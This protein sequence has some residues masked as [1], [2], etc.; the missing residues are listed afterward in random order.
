[1]NATIDE[2]NRAA[3]ERRQGRST[4]ILGADVVS[5]SITW[6]NEL[7]KND[8]ISEIMI[9][10]LDHIFVEEAGVLK[11]LPFTIE[12]WEALDVLVNHIMKLCGI[13]KQ[14]SI[15]YYDGMLPDGS[16][17]AIVLPP[18][19]AD[20]ISIAVRKKCKNMMTFDVMVERGIMPQKVADFMKALAEVRVSVLI[21]GSTSSGKTTLLNALSAFI[22]KD[23]RV[24]T[25]EDTAELQ[26]QHK[27]VVRLESNE[28][29]K[30]ITQRELVKSALRLR[31]D[32]IVMGELRGDEAL[33]FMQAINTGHDGSMAT[34]HANS[35][36]DAFMRLEMMVNMSGVSLTPKFIHQ[37]IASSLNIVIQARRND[38]GKRYITH[39]TEIIGLEGDII[40]S[41]DLFN[42][43]T[44]PKTGKSSYQWCNFSSRNPKIQEAIRRA[45]LQ[46]S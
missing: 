21:S 46:G 20:G 23:E 8:E 29:K 34:I 14:D 16:R 42:L 10:Q 33:D 35:P 3:F 22:S 5:T 7:L 27:N 12:S 18:A 40:V 25:I 2:S 32:R 31:G 28:S 6:F 11:H 15:Q 26:L 30:G 4:T 17:V 1:M 44:D 41:Q 9:N 19:A 36:R 37:Q 38:D 24:I 43:V 13:Y 45:K 39:I